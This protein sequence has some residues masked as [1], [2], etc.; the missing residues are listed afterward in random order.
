MSLRRL[1]ELPVVLGLLGAAILACGADAPL[2]RI[3]IVGSLSYLHHPAS[4]RA[5]NIGEIVIVAAAGLSIVSVLLKRLRVLWFT[6]ALALAQLVTTVVLFEHDAAAVVAKA[7]QPDLVDPVIMWAGS[8]LQHSHIDWGVAV[9][10]GGAMMVL[11]AAVCGR[12]N[13]LKWNDT[14]AV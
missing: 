1:F 7:D 14:S 13:P 6:G 10:A 11:A 12:R 4:F 3:P 2:I 8:A 5:C 9:V